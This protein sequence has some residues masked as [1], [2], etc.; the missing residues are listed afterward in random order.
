M[1]AVRARL[2]GSLASY[3]RSDE[4]SRASIA[5]VLRERPGDGGGGPA[6]ALEAAFILRSINPNDRWS[7]HV[8][9]P[10]GRQEPGEDDVQTAV[11]E[12]FEEVGWD[13][14]PGG[15]A[16][17]LIGRMDDRPAFLG[18]TVCCI[19][20]AQTAVVTPPVHL[21][22][23]EVA[24]IGWCPLSALTLGPESITPLPK[25]IHIVLREGDRLA[26]AA[27]DIFGPREIHY[28]SVVLPVTEVH[29][30][31]FEADVQ[32]RFVLWG[33]TLFVMMDFLILV[34]LRQDKLQLQTIMC[35]RWPIEKV[36]NSQWQSLAVI[37]VKYVSNDIMGNSIFSSQAARRLLQVEAWASMGTVIALVAGGCGRVLRRRPRRSRL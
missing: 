22:P 37:A 35:G 36:C 30:S 15:Q 20:F 18:P 3:K 4:G 1:D 34:G 21:A 13:L 24:A 5:L 12:T 6:E 28:T 10:G 31:S 32:G 8:A 19:V 9:L 23:S 17:D 14:S 16:F 26:R 7:G 11:R 2:R 27:A 33:L 29:S 25:D